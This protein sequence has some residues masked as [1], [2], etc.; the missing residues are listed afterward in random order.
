MISSKKKL[1]CN[2][3]NKSYEIFTRNVKRFSK[4]SP[5]ILKI[6]YMKRLYTI[7][8]LPR[9]KLIFATFAQG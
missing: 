6:N 1:R 5:S 3:I 7:F 9:I 8:N 2:L 4:A